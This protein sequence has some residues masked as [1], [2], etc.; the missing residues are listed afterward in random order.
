[1]KGIRRFL[2]EET[3]KKYAEKISKNEINPHFIYDGRTNGLILNPKDQNTPLEVIGFGIYRLDSNIV[4]HETGINE[5]VIIPEQGE[6]EVKVNGKNFF[7]IRED[8]FPKDTEKSTGSALYIPCRSEIIIQGCGEIAFFEAPAFEEKPPFFLSN[9]EVKV[10][11]RGQWIWRREVTT[12]ITPQNASSNLV[13][14]ETYNP[15]GFWSGT[16][17]HKHDKDQ[18]NLGESDHEEVY[19]FRF[20]K[21]KDFDDQFGPYGVQILMDEGGLRNAYLIG[22]NSIFAIPG[23]CHP[24]VIS[25]FSEVIYLW[26]LAGKGNKLMMRDV[27]EFIFLKHFEEI[28]MELDKE[29]EKRTIPKE[30]FQKLCSLYTFTEYQKRL[31]KVMLKE[32]GFETEI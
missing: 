18:P 14:G 21:K 5:M 27:Y 16:P 8:L 20:R 1:M 12:F 30:K 6:F 31:L 9:Q 3:M 10:V 22:D 23:G 32:K 19:Y 13:V 28:F 25:P 15:P 24:V 11:S 17:L 4:Y 29:I 26:G 2:V 7:M